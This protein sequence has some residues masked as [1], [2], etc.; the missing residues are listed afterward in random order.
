[1]I[2][3][4]SPDTP[5]KLF[6]DTAL[7][8]IAKSVAGISGD[9]RKALDVARR[10]LDRVALRTQEA[11]EEG[12][13]R[14]TIQDAT[15]AYNE[16]T[17]TGPAFFVKRLSLHEKV[18]LLA[19]AQCVRRAGVPDVEL[20]SVSSRLPLFPCPGFA[21]LVSDHGAGPELARQFPATDTPLVVYCLPFKIRPHDL[22][23]ATS[24]DATRRDG[25][26]TARRLSES[27]SGDR[28]RRRLCCPPGRRVVEEP[29]PASLALSPYSSLSCLFHFSHY[30]FTCRNTSLSI[31]SLS[32]T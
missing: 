10:T 19:L 9:A 6:E 2:A 13:V 26:S 4:G 16:M 5:V 29:C 3:N 17:K 11:G 14:C 30:L 8:K 7:Q 24:L 20:E 21:D 1:M 23:L 25:I 31:F 15:Q 28:G 22:D 27:S 12:V 18:L 32:W